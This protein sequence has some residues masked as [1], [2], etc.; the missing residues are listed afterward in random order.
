MVGFKGAHCVQDMI[1]ICVWW[2]EA[3]PLNYR[4]LEAMMQERGVSVDHS[5]INC[6][7][8]TDSP[9]LEA[10]F[11]RRNRPVWLRWWMD[12]TYIKIKDQWC[13]LY[14]TVDTSGQTSECLHTA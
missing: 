7:V 13:Y 8:L 14:R 1:L 10:A 3:Y 2:Y 12:E 6:E 5:T 9:P 4:C 11:H